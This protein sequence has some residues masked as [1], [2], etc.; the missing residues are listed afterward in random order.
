MPFVIYTSSKILVRPSKSLEM[1]LKTLI[2][3]LVLERD[4]GSL[5]TKDERMANLGYEPAFKAEGVEG[6]LSFSD[7]GFC[8]LLQRD[9]PRVDFHGFEALSANLHQMLKFLN[10]DYFIDVTK[11]KSQ[12]FVEGMPVPCHDLYKVNP[13]GFDN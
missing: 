6:E 2:R 1:K 13:P 8:C 10:R 11:L 5:S 9:F 12:G 4:F 7:L 3:I